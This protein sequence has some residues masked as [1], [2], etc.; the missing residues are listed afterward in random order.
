VLELLLV[1][2][3]TGHLI[4]VNVAA[5]GPLY[6][7]AVE[8]RASRRGEQAAQQAARRL[9]VWSLIGFVLGMIIGG[10]LLGI[11]WHNDRA[12]WSAVGRVPVHRWWFFGG[13]VVFYFACMI[14]YVLLWDRHVAASPRDAVASLGEPRGRWWHRLLAVLAATNLLYHFPPLFTMLSL[15]TSRPELSGEALDRTLYVELFTDPETLARVAHHW[16]SATATT[17]VGLMLLATRPRAAGGRTAVFAARVALAA[18]VVQLPVGLW[19]LL[20]SPSGTQ[21]QLLGGDALGTAL[22]VGA[23]LA[24][25]VLLQ[26]LLTAA[27]GDDSRKTAVKSALLLL[28]VLLLMSGALHRTRVRN[29][30]E[31]LVSTPAGDA[32]S[33][34]PHSR[35]SGAHSHQSR[36]TGRHNRVCRRMVRTTGT[37]LD[38]RTGPFDRRLPA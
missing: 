3:F 15:M 12:Y 7:V 36:R 13:E 5:A 31:P 32:F 26:Q 20:V 22:F 9:A 34:L 35:H 23:I 25:V 17:G 11:L 1:V 16:L 19:L 10:G 28:V 37:I 33:G 29:S 8:W 38:R 21:S 6:C 30:P 24:A 2:A 4:A 27:L 18:T 14:P